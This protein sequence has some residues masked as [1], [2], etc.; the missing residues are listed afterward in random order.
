MKAYLDAKG[1]DYNSSAKKADLL[2]LV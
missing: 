1:V 2:E